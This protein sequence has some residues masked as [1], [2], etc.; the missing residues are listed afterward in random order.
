MAYDLWQTIFFIRGHGGVSSP[1]FL[2]RALPLPHQEVESI[3]SPT[4]LVGDPGLLADQK[5][6]VE[7]TVC[8]FQMQPL[9]SLAAST[10]VL[11]GSQSSCCKGAQARLLNDKT[12]CEEKHH[13][14]E[15]NM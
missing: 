2:S 14:A 10:V 15:P 5:N 6:T 3:S 8:Q 12:P 7:E 1:T 11:W 4:D 13:G 9:G